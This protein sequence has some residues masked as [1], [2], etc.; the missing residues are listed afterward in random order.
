MIDVEPLIVSELEVLLPLPDG[1]RADWQDVVRRARLD[2]RRFVPS[3]RIAVVVVAA[4]VVAAA[5]A[6]T[7][8]IGGAI[9]RT[10]DGFSAWVSGE[11]G[12]PASPAEQQAFQQANAR[13]WTAFAP[14]TELRRLIETSGNGTTYTLYG[15]RSGDALCL[16]LV[17]T[18]AVS[19]ISTHCAPLQALQSAR[20]PAL[21]VAADEP[22]GSTNTP[23]N[24]QGYVPA[25]AA[26][27]FGIVSDGVAQVLLHADDGSHDAIVAS[28]AFLYVAERPKLGVRVRGVEAIAGNGARV[29]L[30]FQS[31]PYG[32]VDLPQPPKGTAQGPSHVDRQVSGGAIG[33][34][35]RLESRG[36]PIPQTLLDRLLVVN[37]FGRLLLARLI[38]PDPND[39]LRVGVAAFSG[40][41]SLASPRSTLC[42]F[43]VDQGPISGGCS[44]LH[45]FFERSSISVGISG[46]GSSQFSLLSGLASDDVAQIKV[47]LASGVT[48]SVPLKDNAFV[49]RVS[50]DAYPIRIVGYD[51]KANVID[52][53]TLQSDGM[54][55]PA[56]PEA[57][58][59][60]RERYQASAAD[61]T[62]ATVRA[63]DPAGGYRC[64]SI[65][66]G[67]GGQEEGGCTQW[68]LT[69]AMTK[70]NALLLVSA[71]TVG[72]DVFLGG[73]VPVTV[74]SVTVTFPNGS[75]GTV[76]AKDGFV[77][78][79]VPP[80]NLTEGTVAVTL[81]AYD[82]AGKQLAQR[83]LRLKHP[84]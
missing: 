69:D 8:P 12:T 25:A 63:G 2:R 55:N 27:S 81:R 65:S 30:P 64:W 67:S 78:Y 40:T 72:E 68:P 57:R 61:G 10:L 15:F 52:I 4:V 18:G 60:I 58:T 80:A 36:E 74:A 7:T 42:M 24:D 17:A 14:G 23:P 1:G 29:A 32:T 22:V 37:R 62:T 43:L 3:R 19:V 84:H 51:S 79:P 82:A 46:S 54:T 20:Q 76:Q 71:S 50:R 38:Q 16:R 5:V 39:F 44:P 21:V 48:I 53:Q 11:P 45:Q 33:W 70:G 31:A 41:G 47:F 6:A 28:N 59:S 77:V 35:E 49:T 56:P 83:G 66:Y 75:S 73:Q 13:S 34:V 26:A 9:A